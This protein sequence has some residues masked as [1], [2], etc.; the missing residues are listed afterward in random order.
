LNLEAGEGS[1]TSAPGD[2]LY[3]GA[4]LDWN[5]EELVELEGEV[6]YPGVYVIREGR[7]TLRELIER[8]GGFT[9]DADPRGTYVERPEVFDPPEKDPELERLQNIPVDDMTKDE[10]AYWKL[11]SVQRQGQSSAVLS[12]DS[13]DLQ[14]EELTLRDGDHVHVPKKNLSVDVQGAIKNPGFLP[15]DEERNAKDYIELAGGVS[16]R[17]RSGS[18]RIIRH[19]TGEWVDADKKTRVEPG[20]TVWVPERPA[21]NGWRTVREVVTFLASVGTI[22]V[23]ID[24]VNR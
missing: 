15:Y 13:F 4:D 16:E 3:I 5:E 18:V 6:R 19:R 23:V 12:V 1:T 7:E 10:Y 22:V 11:R 17:A 8:A 24:S 20:D 9:A 21:R 2:A 14:A